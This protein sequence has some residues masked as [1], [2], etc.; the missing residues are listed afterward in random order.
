[1]RQIRLLQPLLSR[2]MLTT[3]LLDNLGAKC[4]ANGSINIASV[5]ICS[6]VYLKLI[7]SLTTK[8]LISMCFELD[9]LLF[10][11]ENTT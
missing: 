6:K 2:P 9:L 8:Y 11:E 3:C 7:L 4:L 10:L 1:M 5:W